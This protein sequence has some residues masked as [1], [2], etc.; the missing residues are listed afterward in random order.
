M[1]HLC[2]MMGITVN[3]PANFT[4]EGYQQSK[5]TRTP[6]KTRISKST[7]IGMLIHWDFCG[8]IRSGGISGIKYFVT[9]VDNFSG[10]IWIQLLTDKS[11]NTILDNFKIILNWFQRQ[12]NTKIKTLRTVNGTE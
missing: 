4:C 10:F 3:R 9:F 6:F 11:S 8:P 5:Q 12:T 2:G 1:N 7:E